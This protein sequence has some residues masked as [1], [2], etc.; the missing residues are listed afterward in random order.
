VARDT[1]YNNTCLRC[2][3]KDTGPQAAVS[4]GLLSPQ[5]INNAQEQH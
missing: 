1:S 5:C 4:L 2:V 3:D